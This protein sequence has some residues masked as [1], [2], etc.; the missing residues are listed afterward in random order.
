MRFF[1]GSSGMTRQLAGD[2]DEK[3]GRYIFKPQ[4]GNRRLDE[5]SIGRGIRV[6]NLSRKM[7]FSL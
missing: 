1:V 4:V 2:F 3:L 6:V 7:K 5:S